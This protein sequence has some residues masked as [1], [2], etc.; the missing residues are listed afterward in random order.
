MSCV[1]G[2]VR[3]TIANIRC[4]DTTKS[5]MSPYSFVRADGDDKKREDCVAP[6]ALRRDERGVFA[7]SKMWGAELCQTCCACAQS[8]GRWLDRDK[9]DND[10]G[11]SGS[12]NSIQMVERLDCDRGSF[13]QAELVA[14]PCTSK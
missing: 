2:N 6:R 5:S 8:E 9:G 3:D 13:Q 10:Q 1:A 4:G 12:E 14:Q 7:F 11:T